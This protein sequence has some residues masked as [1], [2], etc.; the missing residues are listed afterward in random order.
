M[1]ATDMAATEYIILVDQQDQ[2]IGLAEKL[3]AHQQKLLHR[4]FSIFIFRNQ[5]LLLQQRG[6]DK[7]HCAGLWTNTCCSHPRPNESII[8]AGKRRLKEELNMDGH[9]IHLKNVGWFHYQAQF[10]NG[11]TENEI[12]HVL[13]GSLDH[14]TDITFTPNH[15]EI[16]ALKWMN[17]NELEEELQHNPQQFTPWFE[18]AF[19][20]ALMG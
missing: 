20:M 10:A 17:V 2:E 6:L 1:A 18:R 5:Q 4:A 12:D 14:E 16:H 15:E 7:Y 8:A 13:V 19:R 3:I 11:L 9:N